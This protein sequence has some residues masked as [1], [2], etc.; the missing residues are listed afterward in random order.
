MKEIWKDIEGYEGFYQV[1]NLG[2][3]KSLDRHDAFDRL[4]K[5]KMITPRKNNYK[6][7]DGDEYVY[8][9]LYRNGKGKRK[10]VH[11]LVAE[12]FV[13]RVAECN[14]VNHLDGTRS[15]NRADNLEWTT[16]KGN[17]LHALNNG[18]LDSAIEAREKAVI[19]IDANG[20]EHYFKSMS[21]AERTL[22]LPKGA[23][24]PISRCCRGEYG[25]KTAYG[26]KW[27]YAE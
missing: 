16:K 1:S 4:V 13:P 10:Y 21:I 18:R 20:E 7:I 3:V 2:R 8:V 24:T 27:R 11:R 5:G 12:A 15:N 17:T 9:D 14:V 25:C 26:Y 22:D 19:S 6:N 23:R